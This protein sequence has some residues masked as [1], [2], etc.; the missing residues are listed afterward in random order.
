M[1]YMINSI[2]NTVEWRRW[3]LTT[4]THSNYITKYVNKHI[5][6]ILQNASKAAEM[7]DISAGIVHSEVPQNNE[8]VK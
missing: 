2:Y 1:K 8:F 7:S 3:C 5:V 6:Y 4:V